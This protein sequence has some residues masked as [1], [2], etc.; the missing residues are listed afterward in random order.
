MTRAG[1]YPS[2][3][4]HTRFSSNRLISRID[5]SALAAVFTV[6]ATGLLLI[7]SMSFTFHDGMSADVP[8]VRNAVGLWGA[9]R[10]DALV[11][12]VLRDGQLFFDAKKITSEELTAQLRAR[13]HAGAPR[14]VYIRADGHVR[15]SAVASVLESIRSAGLTNLAFLTEQRR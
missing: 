2:R 10:E 5:A 15:Y 4:L 13:V 14:E 6:L 3:M 8:S 7:Q 1:V 12:F 11:I 9:Q